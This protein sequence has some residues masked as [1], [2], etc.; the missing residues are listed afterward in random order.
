M[1]KIKLKTLFQ[2]SLEKNKIYGHYGHIKDLPKSKFGVEIERVLSPI[3]DHLG[4]S[5]V[6]EG[7][8]KRD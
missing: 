7:D 4:K 3:T 1:L 2:I 8:V 6:V 5:K